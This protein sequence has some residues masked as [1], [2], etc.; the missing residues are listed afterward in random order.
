MSGK[1]VQLITE[2]FPGKKLIKCLLP[3]KH[4]ALGFNDRLAYSW[5]VYRARYGKGASR[6]QLAAATGLHR[7]KTIPRLLTR[8]LDLG[9]V[10]WR[11]RKVF[12]KEPS[13]ELFVYTSDPRRQ[14]DPWFKRLAYFYVMSPSSSCPLTIMQVGVL[15]LLFSPNMRDGLHVAPRKKHIAALLR[16]S[17]KTVKTALRKLEEVGCLKDDLLLRPTPEMQGWW[18]DRAK[19]EKVATVKC[20]QEPSWDNYSKTLHQLLT[21]LDAWSCDDWQ[22]TINRIGRTFQQAGY[23]FVEA[24]NVLVDA[25]QRTSQYG[26]KNSSTGYQHGG[27]GQEG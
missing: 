11:G 5:L 13:P 9:L 26:R 14:N 24:S 1:S 17:E 22:G 23:P 19:R 4:V 20:D 12:A 18:Q 25:V 16:I 21:K 15:C 2:W 27:T 7:T 6:S 3:R 8:L 10:E